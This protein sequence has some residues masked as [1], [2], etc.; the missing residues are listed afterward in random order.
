MHRSD[1]R[2][3]S[4]G[5]SRGRLACR[6]KEIRTGS[7]TADDG[8]EESGDEMRVNSLVG[9]TCTSS[10]GGQDQLTLLS[11]GKKEKGSHVS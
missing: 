5:I 6:G 9:P 7:T 11:A 4:D 3:L 2:I 1:K 10:G 8:L